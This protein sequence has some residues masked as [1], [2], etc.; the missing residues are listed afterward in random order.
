MKYGRHGDHSDS[1]SS[2]PTQ[3]RGGSPPKTVKFI[4]ENTLERHYRK[5]QIKQDNVLDTIL[6]EDELE[7]EEDSSSSSNG[8]GLYN[9]Y[10]T[11]KL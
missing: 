7:G 2:S 3:S 1:D 9:I 6:S 4:D 8:S 10:I 11:T 5:K